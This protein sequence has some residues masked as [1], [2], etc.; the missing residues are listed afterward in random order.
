MFNTAINLIAMGGLL[1]LAQPRLYATV[2]ESVREIPI[3]KEVDVVVIGG[4]SGAA[5]AAISAAEAGARVFLLAPRSYLGEDMCA[6]LRLWLEEGETPT[7]PLAKR[8]FA[9]TTP[10]DRGLLGGL[11]ARDSNALQFT[12]T[13]SLSSVT[14]HKDTEPPTL[15]NDGVYD[16]AERNSVQYNGDV[17]IIAD[18]GALRKVKETRL[19]LYHREGGDFNPGEVTV[20]ISPD[21]AK[22]EEMSKS[23][24]PDPQQGVIQLTVAL[25]ASTRY[26]RYNIHRQPGGKRVLLGEIE[27]IGQPEVS[28]MPVKISP[29]KPADYDRF[30]KMLTPMSVKRRFDEALV[31]AKVDFLFGS[32]PTELLVD[33]QNNPCGVIMAN[34]SGRQAVLAKVIIDATPRATVARMAGAQ[35]QPYPAGEYE[36]KRVVVG[37]EVQTGPKISGRKLGLKFLAKASKTEPAHEAELIE[38]TLRLP[39]KDG[40]FASFSETEQLARDLTWHAGTLDASDNLFQ[41]PPDAMRG[42]R[43]NRDSASTADTLDLDVC[44]PYGSSRIY[45]LG[46]CVDVP[47]DQAARI[48]RPLALMN[49]GAQIGAAAAKEAGSL[50]AIKGPKV[51]SGSAIR[52]TPKTSTFPG[53]VK[54]FLNGLRP[55]QRPTA[56]L[57]SPARNLPVLGVYDVVVVGGGTG[58]GSGGHWCGPRGRENIGVGISAR[59]GRSWHRRDDQPVLL[60]FLGWIYGG[61]G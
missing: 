52:E 54:E 42:K 56:T 11:G 61:S 5:S 49:L 40:S 39:M 33:A 9:E 34:R 50:P 22:W 23:G 59:P 35:F 18:L 14:P 30:V 20:A 43:S 29:P 25:G 13:A 38:Y 47:R 32:F 45:V 55:T 60:W 4:S 1:A 44:R 17:E 8:L 12:Y 31:E 41:V 53:E 27:L 36:F 37:G 2:N 7:L 46:G 58:G 48:L 3:V 26:V 24:C 57:T 28:P 21:K 51:A 6:T 19:V 10:A 16:R 15:L